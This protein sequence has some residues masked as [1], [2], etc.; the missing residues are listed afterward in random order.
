MEKM[1]KLTML[2][3]LCLVNF[4]K[5][6]YKHLSTIQALESAKPPKKYAFA[7]SMDPMAH[8]KNFNQT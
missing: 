5:F 7:D 6:Y 8:V 2:E 3:K 1:P 4:F